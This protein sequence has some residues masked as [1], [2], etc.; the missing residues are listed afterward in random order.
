MSLK[1]VEK[2]S[3]TRKKTKLAGLEIGSDSR[4]VVCQTVVC[5]SLVCQQQRKLIWMRHD[6]NSTVLLP[7]S[8]EGGSIRCTRW[9]TLICIQLVISIFIIHCR[10][11]PAGGEIKADVADDSRRRTRRSLTTLKLSTRVDQQPPVRGWSGRWLG[12]VF[13]LLT[14][15]LAV[16]MPADFHTFCKA[17]SSN[18]LKPVELAGALL[19]NKTNLL[20]HRAYYG[21]DVR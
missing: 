11:R 1:C 5:L 21:Q 7:W 2:L 6:Y 14:G 16:A 10:L 17:D 18:S 20:N 3:E 13:R 12:T 19:L 4:K 9:R 15:K 8:T